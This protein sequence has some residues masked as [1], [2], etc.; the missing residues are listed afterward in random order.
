M[1]IVDRINAMKKEGRRGEGKRIFLLLKN[2]IAS[3]LREG[4]TIKVVWRSLTDQNAIDISYRTFAEYVARYIPLKERTPDTI[5]LNSSE[6]SSSVKSKE[7]RLEL[8]KEQQGL[9]NAVADK[10][11][12]I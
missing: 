4:Y 7:E 1:S 10:D 11:S 6:Q 12:L 9:H 5:D 8:L 2:E 3:A